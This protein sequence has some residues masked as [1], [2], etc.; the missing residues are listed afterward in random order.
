[1]RLLKAFCL[2]SLAAF[3][4]FS[5]PVEI[6]VLA[7][8]DLHGNIYP[9]DYQTG[10][11][12]DRGLAKIATLIAEQRK[13]N[14]NVIL[15]DCGDTIQGSPIESVYQQWVRTG[16]F[17]LNLKPAAPLRGDPMMLAMNHLRYDAMTVGNHEFNF[18]LGNLEKAR[19]A[20]RFPW[21]SA[22]AKAQ[23]SSGRKPF[24]PY[25][26][27]TVAGVKVAI[28]GITTPAVP[29]WEK[30]EN[31]KDYRFEDA[32]AAA[33]E[34]LADAR[35]H[36]PDL[37]I[38]AAHAG[39]ERDIKTGAIR[40][41]DQ[42]KENMVYQIASEIPGID[43][44]VFGHTHQQ[45]DDF[46]LNGVLLTQP[47]NW[48]I[49][50]ARMSF[51]LESTP[52]GAYRVVK[53][54]ATLIPVTR[55]TVP[56]PDV[57]RIAKPYHD[58]TEA[59]LNSKVSRTDGQMSASQSRIEDT[60]IIDAI[61]RAQMHYAQADVSFTAAF[62]VRAAIPEGTV[63][64]RKIAALYVYDNE[65]YAIQGNGKMVREALENS[66][67]FY[68]TCRDP[69]CTKGPL[70][71]RSIIGY[72]FDIA[73]GVTYTIDLTKQVGQRVGNL[74]YRG[75]PLTDNQPL[76]I[77]I[78]NYRYGG[79]GGFTMFRGAKLLWRSFE[80]IRDLIIRYYSENPLPSQP[81]NNW[82]VIPESAH[83]VLEA[84]TAQFGGSAGTQ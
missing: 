20:A 54:S 73:H 77:A 29:S 16:K 75:E 18:G 50:L 43:A 15:I 46:R 47:K 21:I 39:L 13:Q 3:C 80:D 52:G 30:P 81:D 44:I 45:L 84:E 56:D 76:R 55:D 31:F 4:A 37:V 53:K 1:M 60:A 62:N 14:P 48:G 38:V 28:I 32:K 26:L 49:S 17:P 11:P 7:T 66:A 22:N 57:L 51:E 42:Q 61:Q 72:N 74:K 6:N 23:P 70:I 64:V 68:N 34:A 69:Q 35:K 9:Y 79:S 59:Y 82:R 27:K 25:A 41:G 5:K 24:A 67:R 12:A 83:R 10:Q 19:A 33:M 40:Q 2:F 8:T 65:L 63:T 58:L 36:K 71:N 78:N